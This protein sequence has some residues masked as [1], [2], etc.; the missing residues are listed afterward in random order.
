MSSKIGRMT[1]H[2]LAEALR[3]RQRAHG[4]LQDS[5]IDACSDDDIINSYITCDCCGEKQIEGELLEFA[6]SECESADHFFDLCD[7]FATQ[8]KV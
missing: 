7:D 1:K 4:E 6:I 2:D 5:V 8:A 3:L